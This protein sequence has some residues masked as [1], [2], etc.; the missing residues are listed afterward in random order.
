MPAGIFAKDVL[1]Q[2]FDERLVKRLGNPQ[3]LLGALMLLGVAGHLGQ[4]PAQFQLRH[5]L[6]RERPQRIRLRGS[7]RARLIIQNGKRAQGEAVRRD[8]RHGGE[9]PDARLTCDQGVIREPWVGRRVVNDEQFGFKN[10]V[11]GKGPAAIGPGKFQSD[12]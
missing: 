12:A 8:N 10:R 3:T 7:Q 2:A 11:S 9:E 6:V 4:V 5:D 1:W